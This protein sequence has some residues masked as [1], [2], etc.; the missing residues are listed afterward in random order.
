M[1]VTT[2]ATAPTGQVLNI[3]APGYYYFNGA[4]WVKMLANSDKPD[5]YFTN[6]NNLTNIL[7]AQTLGGESS[8]ALGVNAARNNSGNRIIA[9]GDGAAELNLANQVVAIG[10]NAARTNTA[11][12]V[13]AIGQGAARDNIGFHLIAIGNFSAQT[14]SGI[15]VNALGFEAARNNAGDYVNAFG[16]EA[17]RGSTQN[18]VNA[19]GY[20][21]ARNNSG[22]NLIAIGRESGLNNA[23]NNNIFIGSVLNEA[24]L[25]NNN[26]LIGRQISLPDNAANHQL[27]IQNIIFGAGNDTFHDDV[28]N[29][30]IGI[31]VRAPNSKLHVG[32]S[33]AANIR[34]LASGTVTESDYTVLVQGNVSLPSPADRTGRIYNLI[35]DNTNVNRVTG[36]FKMNGGTLTFY[37][38]NDTDNGRGVTVQSDGT[39]WVIISRY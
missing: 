1:Y 12:H 36:T 34:V 13:N 39:A 14:N 9:I 10:Q 29:G 16:F 35:N 3:T 32:G 33:V 4:F 21:A 25:G 17:A 22:N 28:S 11:I 2:R 31:G 30:M 20:Y 26:I 5:V 37:D 18:H 7:T 15:Y 38:L 27:N 19:F 6:N 8:V 24:V 23:G